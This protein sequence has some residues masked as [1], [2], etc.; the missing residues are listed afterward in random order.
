ME[1]RFRPDDGYSK[2]ACGDR[3]TTCGFLLR[4]RVKKSR[5]EKVNHEEARINST[6]RSEIFKM[7]FSSKNIDTLEEHNNSGETT[8]PSQNIPPTFDKQKCENLSQDNDYD[9]PK[10]K[11]LGRVDIEFRFTSML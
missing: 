3:H 9:L 5:V 7:D 1:L 8:N 4:V 6:P 10:L 11:I 2:P